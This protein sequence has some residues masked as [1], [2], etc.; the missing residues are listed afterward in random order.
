[1]GKVYT[2]EF[3]YNSP[4]LHDRLLNY[5]SLDDSLMR[6]EQTSI[7]FHEAIDAVFYLCDARCV[8][9]GD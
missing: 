3:V 4:F 5:V 2:Y 6:G 8:S 9:P 7:T 1:M